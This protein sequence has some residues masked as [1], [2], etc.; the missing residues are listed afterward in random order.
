[1]VD[2]KIEKSGNRI[3]A[4]VLS[5][6][7]VMI[8]GLIVAIVVVKVKGGDMGAI[9]ADCGQEVS[10]VDIVNCVEK[11]YAEEESYE[12][13]HEIIENRTTG[14]G[15]KN[16]DEI[17]SSYQ[18]FVDAVKSDNVVAA[19]LTMRANKI[20]SLDYEKAYG[21]VVIEDVIMAD[22]IMDDIDSAV[23]VAN[24]ANYYDNTGITEEYSAKIIERQIAAGVNIEAEGEG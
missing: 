10:V 4:V 22:E 9:A 15:L 7:A 6:L 3:W 18:E 14:V 12:I 17:I 2:G 23:N 8:V 21:D 16:I 19:L 5:F 1:M 11:K 24:V 13:Y 20:M